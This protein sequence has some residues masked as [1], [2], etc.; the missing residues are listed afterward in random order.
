MIEADRRAA[1]AIL[2]TVETEPHLLDFIFI[3]TSKLR[4]AE[5]G[6]K[7]APCFALL[8]LNSKSGCDSEG[9]HSVPPPWDCCWD[10]YVRWKQ[11]KVTK[12]GF[13]SRCV[14]SVRTCLVVS[15]CRQPSPVIL[16]SFPTLKVKFERA[17]GRSDAGS[18]TCSGM[19]PQL[20]DPAAS[21]PG[22][23]KHALMATKPATNWPLMPGIEPS[24]GMLFIRK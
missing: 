11:L 21:A 14:W 15:K 19:E 1:V 10:Y 24:T 16:A 17:S 6:K 4:L 23:A 3:V 8:R 9:I 12:L 22:D 13:I 18:L 5:G 20:M 7:K 2:A